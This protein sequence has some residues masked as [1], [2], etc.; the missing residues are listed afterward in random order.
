LGNRT[1]ASARSDSLGER[2]SVK[3]AV[4]ERTYSKA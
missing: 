1:S 2:F 3:G 4:T